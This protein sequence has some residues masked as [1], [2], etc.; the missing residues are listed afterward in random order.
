VTHWG[1]DAV[2]PH[3][4]AAPDGA[5]RA[6]DRH[7]L[8]EAKSEQLAGGAVSAKVA[9][10]A[11]THPTWVHRELDWSPDAPAV[12]FL[13]TPRDA[14]DDQAQTVV[15]N[16]VRL[17]SP[18]DVRALAR[19]TVEMWRALIPRA[20]ALTRLELAEAFDTELAGRGHFDE[21]LPAT[22][23]SRPAVP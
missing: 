3:L 15:A 23:N 19:R 13:V 18:A 7:V 8:W 12:T 1:F 10:Q 14:L 11:S 20:Q 17:T 6:S 21:D 2:R 22:L 16:H 4:P 9:R 5:W